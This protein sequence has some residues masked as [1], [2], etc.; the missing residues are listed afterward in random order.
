MS[1]SVV[2]ALGAWAKGNIGQHFWEANL[3]GLP[4]ANW[5]G[6]KA[7][8]ASERAVREF[9]VQPARSRRAPLFDRDLRPAEPSMPPAHIVGYRGVGR[10][11]TRETQ[12]Q[13]LLQLESEM[14]TV[15]REQNEPERV[16]AAIIIAVSRMMGWSGGA[17]LAQIPGHDLAQVRE[18]WGLPAI[19]RMLGDLPRQIPIGPDSVEAKAWKGQAIWMRD[20]TL[21]PTFAERYQAAGDRHAGGVPRADLRRAEERPLGAALLLAASAFGPTPSFRRW[22]TSCRAPCRCTCSARLP[23]SAWC[24]PRCTTP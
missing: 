12:Q 2:A 8:L 13:L 18:R 10:N 16:V 14:A 22:R 11:V 4:R 19:T 17:H 9:P 6:F 7:D 15:M 24:M 5:D 3:I 1:E 23:R 20:V 21:H